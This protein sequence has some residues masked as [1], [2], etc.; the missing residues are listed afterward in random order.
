MR[1][2]GLRFSTLGIKRTHPAYELARQQGYVELNVWATA[3]GS[4]E[5]AHQPTRLHARSLGAKGYDLVEQIFQGIARDYLG[6]AWRHTPFAGFRMVDP[7]DIWILSE[8]DRCVGYAIAHSDAA[9][10]S[11]SSVLLQQGVD[12]AEALAAITAQVKAAYV[13][14]EVARPTEIASL[15]RAGYRVT[16][17]TL[18]SFLVRPLTPEV[19][20][21]D[22]RL[23]FGIGTDRFL[24]SWMDVTGE[25]HAM[26]PAS[27]RTS[28]E[29]DT[30][31]R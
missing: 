16:Y 11:I 19:T 12:I 10:L 18:S 31:R 22:A 1:A 5:T 4:W 17:P 28:S 29:L 24:I 14:I 30:T 27:H 2:V 8:T 20:S 21:D 13:T 23:L 25:P 6:F 26:G 3:L 15:R 7:T 9:V